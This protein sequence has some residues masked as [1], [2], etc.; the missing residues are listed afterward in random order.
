MIEIYDISGTQ[1]ENSEVLSNLPITSSCQH[2]EEL[3]KEDY[4]SL[5]WN[6]TINYTLPLGSY[7]IPYPEEEDTHSSDSRYPIKYQL[8]SNYEP[9]MKDI[10]H[11]LY[12]PHFEHP[13]MWLKR[14]P[15]MLIENGDEWKDGVK[16]T[17][18]SYTGSASYIAGYIVSCINWLSGEYE[19]FGDMM[20]TG[21]HANVA[22]DLTPTATVSFDSTDIWSG[23]GIIAQA[24]DCEFHFDFE[25]KTFFLG[26]VSSGLETE[27]ELKVG[28]NVGVPSFSRTRED[29]YNSFLVKGSTRNL[30]QQASSGDYEQV[31]GR[32]TLDPEEYPDSTIYVNNDGSLTNREDYMAQDAPAPTLVKELVFD[33][34]YPK[35]EL[36]LYNIR[37]RSCFLMEDDGNGG[38]RKVY[39]DNNQP[40]L[41]S[42]WYFRLAY[43]VY[44]YSGGQK[45]ISQ[46]NDYLSP[47]IISG[48]TL[49]LTFLANTESGAMTSTLIGQGDF[50]M[51]YFSQQ[52]TEKED[53]DVDP[54]GFTAYAGDYRLVFKQEGN[55]IIPTTSSGGMYPQEYDNTNHLPDIRNNKA[56]LLNIVVDDT[57]VNIARDEL[58]RVAKKKIET[59]TADRNNYTLPSNPVYFEQNGTRL[60]LGQKV[61]YNDGQAAQEKTPYLL[62]THVIK[63]V[64][65][66]DYPF[67]Q[68]ITVGNEKV[69]STISTMKEQIQTIIGGGGGSGSGS[70]GGISETQFDSLVQ[71]YGSNYFLSRT[72][73]DTAQ[74]EI[75]FARGLSII[76]NSIT[77]AFKNIVRS[78]DNLSDNGYGSDEAI[79]SEKKALETLL[80]KDRE[81]TLQYMLNLAGGA[82]SDSLTSYSDEY[83]TGDFGIGSGYAIKNEGGRWVL[84]IDD[85]IARRK[86]TV[87]VLDVKRMMFTQGS[88]VLT[89]ANG[90]VKFVKGINADGN[91]I[92]TTIFAIN[93]AT[94]QYVTFQI[95]STMYG[96]REGSVP[97]IS[98]AV[99]YKLYFLKE[100]DGKS[101]FDF[102]RIGDLAL[103]KEINVQSQSDTT[104]YE[105]TDENSSTYGKDVANHHF[106]RLV[107]DHGTEEL[108]DGK[109]YIFVTVSNER[110]STTEYGSQLPKLISLTIPSNSVELSLLPDYDTA[111]Q[112]YP[113]YKRYVSG[114][115]QVGYE[116]NGSFVQ[117]KAW[118]F[119]GSLINSIPAVG[120]DVVQYGSVL[121][122]ER[123]GVT[124]LSPDSKGGVL[125]HV[126]GVGNLIFDTSSSYPQYNITRPSTFSLA[127]NS[128]YRD[129]SK[130]YVE[131]VSALQFTP[132]EENIHLGDEV[133]IIADRFYQ[134]TVRNGNI[135]YYPVPVMM[136]EWVSGVTAYDG[137]QYSYNGELWNC[138]ATE[139]TSVAPGQQD[140]GVTVWAK[141][142]AKGAEGTSPHIGANGNW[143]IGNTDTG[144]PSNSPLYRVMPTRDE[145]V[146]TR[147]SD[148][149]LS[150][151]S[152][153]I[154]FGWI[155]TVGT[156]TTSGVF[157]STS[158]A[159][160]IDDYY[161]LFRYIREDGTPQPTFWNAGNQSYNQ[162]E[163]WDWMT[164]NENN[165]KD[166]E[167]RIIIQNTTQ[168]WDNATS[169]YKT[170]VA[171]E[172]C[173]SSAGASET[174][175]STII[176]KQSVSIT[177]GAMNGQDGQSITG[178]KGEDSWSV[179]C[180]PAL[181][182]LNER[183]MTYADASVT[184]PTGKNVDDIYIDNNGNI[185][186]IWDASAVAKI[187]LYRGYLLKDA[188][189]TGIQLNSTSTVNPSGLVTISINDIDVNNR[190]ATIH[191]D[192]NNVD[193]P[194]NR[195]LTEAV[196]TLNVS[197]VDDT[198]NTS[199]TL[200]VR[201]P[202]HLNRIGTTISQTYG[203]VTTTVAQRMAQT[204]QTVADYYSEWT[205]SANGLSANITAI[206]NYVSSDGTLTANKAKWIAAIDAKADVLTT[207][208]EAYTDNAVGSVT[209]RISTLEQTADAL[210]ARVSDADAVMVPLWTPLNPN[211]SCHYSDVR[212]SYYIDSTTVQTE[213]YRFGSIKNV[214]LEAGETYRLTLIGDFTFSG[215]NT[216]GTAYIKVVCYY[217]TETTDRHV[218]GINNNGKQGH[219]DFVPANSGTYSFA[220][221]YVPRSNPSPNPNDYAILQWW[222]LEQY[223]Y[224]ISSVAEL[225]VE[226]DRIS[227]YVEKTNDNILL[228]TDW[229][230]I[231]T[232]EIGTK[233]TA[234][235]R[236]MTTS[237][238]TIYANETTRTST[239]NQYVKLVE[240][241]YLEYTAIH[242]EKHNTTN[243]S[244]S[245]FMQNLYSANNDSSTH[246]VTASTQY[247]LSFK[248]RSS[249]VGFF[250]GGTMLDKDLPITINGDIY[251]PNEDK[252]GYNF[253]SGDQNRNIRMPST[254][255]V[256]K[257][258]EITFTT[259]SV[260]TNPRMGFN[261]YAT[262]SSVRCIEI[263][264]VKLEAGASATPWTN[265]PDMLA[266]S[267]IDIYAEK[268]VANTDNFEVHNTNGDTTF[269]IDENGNL[270][271]TGSAEF[272]GIVRATTIYHSFFDLIIVPFDFADVS[273]YPRVCT[274]TNIMNRR[275]TIVGNEDL[276]GYLPDFL[277]IT[278]AEKKDVDDRDIYV[279]PATDYYL[280]ELPSPSTYVGKLLEVTLFL[281]GRL[282]DQV[283]Q[284]KGVGVKVP[285]AKFPDGLTSAI[286]PTFRIE[287]LIGDINMARVRMLATASY[288]MILDMQGSNLVME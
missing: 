182:V 168:V 272:R 210:T 53:D 26:K 152:L 143:Y 166:G 75:T 38:K 251:A 229:R 6:D 56:T 198:D 16:K 114:E 209:S 268:I 119:D 82:R 220:A 55:V 86:F 274:F 58:E 10:A 148:N 161:P 158:A 137:Q 256:W 25:N 244:T 71:I 109:T 259:S 107:I 207:Q 81:E 87:S 123:K 108:A 159:T 214:T 285:S 151:A 169:S 96:D 101:V 65:Q 181:V 135:Q 112:D 102:W 242:I 224:P 197:F 281:S 264:L 233:L 122:T 199:G 40:I 273:P 138:T 99:A 253:Q 32:L 124:S 177:K 284:T 67:V 211:S 212:Y 223:T 59:M 21:W 49:G 230:G 187:H 249:S 12:E 178:P 50:D 139:G 2:V 79:L 215:S 222:R 52:T 180:E 113:I 126:R 35:L 275:A 37:E 51:V 237:N 258:V 277:V 24:F 18:W 93:T 219:W 39:D 68:E 239:L 160:K 118:S 267:G 133:R 41:Y 173:L 232:E 132:T 117:I 110:F 63:I 128:A 203:D 120:D 195:T 29:Y 127:D 146:F 60:H 43:P 9:E 134:S 98:S 243:Y 247:T 255:W 104:Q 42:K 147:N 261:V 31:T 84:E 22:S 3:M 170:F 74:G 190:Q 240:N 154:K 73:G 48:Q 185:Q 205:T 188:K 200:Q 263:A 257:T 19:A 89:N 286:A 186:P 227:M 46:W 236:S 23:A 100:Q 156:T 129:A 228:Q 149:T 64:T 201:I 221:Y 11:F 193:S 262:D 47:Q 213:A 130:A 260:L 175:N 216:S 8:F 162:P 153:D 34:I 206:K 234:W 271:A 184:P 14:L 76:W 157:S 241:A 97:D 171:I 248:Y 176:A 36:Y 27:V 269:S 196:V 69:K 78:N 141:L 15:L 95:N 105:D 61:L 62:H 94:N 91:E 1:L 183:I 115:W 45:T 28:Y 250:I 279:S 167:G 252:N 191:I 33:D 54:N 13:L 145:I 282:S 174:T 92:G 103:C 4:V 111:Q 66:L 225:K 265:L 278:T 276:I 266:K 17:S 142:V 172:F 226:S 283:K 194:S 270:Q 204:D 179:T 150:P 192:S 288:W 30:S 246:R 80:R 20:G 125:S 163:G 85:I 231:D 254:N 164:G 238:G 155:K 5:S 235:S 121:Y 287:Q 140:S 202:V 144:V 165:G 218:W 57:Y 90:T 116:Y 136:G 131:Q 83:R 70:G 44:T 7:I 217:G 245:S 72:R 77:K 106:H 189:I 88:Q 280:V 208:Y